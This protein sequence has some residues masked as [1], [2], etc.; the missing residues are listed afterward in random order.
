M[1]IGSV[2]E[3]FPPLDLMGWEYRGKQNVSLGGVCKPWTD[4]RYSY[5]NEHENFCRKILSNIT[6]VSCI[7]AIDNDIHPCEVEACGKYFL[8]SKVISFRRINEFKQLLNATAMVQLKL[9]LTPHLQLSF[10]HNVTL[11]LV[12]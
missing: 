8:N 2:I 4:T 11:F 10:T 5:L 9:L 6:D 7:S 12:F 1:L 3:C